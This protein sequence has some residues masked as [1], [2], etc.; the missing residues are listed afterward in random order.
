MSAFDT[1]IRNADIATA[2]DRYVADI[3]I[4]EG[5]IAAIGKHLGEAK[6]TIDAAGRLVTPG[7]VDAHCHLD[8]P[9]SDGSKMADDFNTGTRSAACGGT[10]TVIPFACQFKGHSLQ[11]AVD[12]GVSMPSRV[13]FIESLRVDRSSSLA[14]FR[15]LTPRKPWLPEPLYGAPASVALSPDGA[16]WIRSPS[17]LVSRTSQLL[18]AAL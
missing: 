13:R 9:M 16:F 7:G 11:E 17:N 18:Y 5:R 3:G 8:Q 6:L 14:S 10:T 2:S 15:P 12:D 4:S 1:V